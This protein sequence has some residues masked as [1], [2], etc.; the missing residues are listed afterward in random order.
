MTTKYTVTC[1]G[2]PSSLEVKSGQI[3]EVQGYRNGNNILANS[4]VNITKEGPRC[5]C[6]MPKP[7]AARGKNVTER[8]KVSNVQQSADFVQFDLETE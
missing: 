3:V 4:V 1:Y 6:Q 2:P 5:L 8:G 7:L